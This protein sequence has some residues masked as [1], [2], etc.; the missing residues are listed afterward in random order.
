[1]HSHHL[2][3]IRLELETMRRIRKSGVHPL[4]VLNQMLNDMYEL[5][6]IGIRKK[7]PHATPEEVEQK[8]REK[9]DFYYKIKRISRIKKDA[10][11]KND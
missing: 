11:S 8:L 4:D 3:K 9:I 1:M 2:D 7:Y 5:A 10:P 6:R